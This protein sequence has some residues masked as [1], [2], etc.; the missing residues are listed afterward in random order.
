[1]ISTV[2]FKKRELPIWTHY[3]FP[4]R[5]MRPKKIQ[6]YF[7]RGAPEHVNSTHHKAKLASPRFILIGC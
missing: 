5:F 1:M 6:V 4:D 7:A 3:L 2:I